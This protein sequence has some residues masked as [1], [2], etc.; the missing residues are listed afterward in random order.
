MESLKDFVKNIAYGIDGAKNDLKV[1]LTTVGQYWKGFTAGWRRNYSAILANIIHSVAYERP[2]IRVNNWADFMAIVCS[3]ARVGEYIE[4]S[5]RTGSGRGL[6][7]KFVRDAKNMTTTLDKRPEY[8]L[9]EGLVPIPLICNLMLPILAILIAA[10]AFRDYD[11]IKELLNISMSIREKIEKAN[12]FSFR[13]RA[14]GFR[15]G[16]SRL[17]TIHD[18]RAEGLYW[19][20]LNTF[21]NYYMPNNSGTDG[22]A[23]YFGIELRSII[24]NL[25]RGL[26]LPRNPKLWQSLPAEKQH[27]LENSSNYINIEEEIA[28]L[29]GKKDLESIARRKELYAQRRKLTAKELRKWQKAQPYRPDIKDED[30]D[31]PCY[32]RTIFNRTRFL[33]PERGRLASTLFKVTT[34]QS[35]TGLSALR[36][37]VA[38]CQKD[39][40]VEFRPGLEPEKCCCSNSAS[41]PDQSPLSDT[42]KKTTYDWSCSADALISETGPW[43]EHIH[44]HVE[45][46]DEGRPVN[47]PHSG[48]QYIATFNSVKS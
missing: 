44:R 3:S 33:M 41:Q 15:T 42:K 40:E 39:A 20:D 26:S 24:N 19:I 48:S 1:A 12:A 7:Y 25:F 32:H 23:S 37:M 36:D 10:K 8:S 21:N 6:H 17:P 2:A 9:Y 29:K 4:S 28:A 16:Y 27:K 30:N 38:L 5:C 14:L 43:K 11:T 46:L 47:Y 18:F 45:R 22:Q 34:L 13:L 35:P 31:S